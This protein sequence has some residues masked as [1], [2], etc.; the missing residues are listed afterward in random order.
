MKYS[1]SEK[2]L[3]E[4]TGISRVELVKFRKKSVPKSEWK[5]SRKGKGGAI[6][7][8][9]P[10]VLR[11]KVRFG[12]E[13]ANLDGA[14]IKGSSGRSRARD[15]KQDTPTPATV[16]DPWEVLNKVRSDTKRGTLDCA[17]FPDP[18]FKEAVAIS[19]NLKLLHVSQL[20]PNKRIL[21]ATNGNLGLG[22]VYNVI[23]PS[24]EVW[25]IGDPLRAK[26]SVNHKGYW[27]L[28]GRAPRWRGD[29]IYRHEF[30]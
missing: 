24:S 29:R 14:R 12:I 16:P 23:V 22:E 18:C 25:A 19:D 9:E 27:E 17:P 15:P 26:E 8:S 7:L 10:A 2:L 3:S 11:V 6:L 1:F 13:E 21:K 30:V 20:V 4:V 28:V 5:K